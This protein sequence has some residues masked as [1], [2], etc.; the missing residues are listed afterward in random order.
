MQLLLLVPFQGT[1]A[2]ILFLLSIF[3]IALSCLNSLTY[4]LRYLGA[5]L[6]QVQ[7]RAFIKSYYQSIEFV[8]VSVISDH[9]R[10]IAQVGRLLMECRNLPNRGNQNFELND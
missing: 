2:L 3:P 6:C 1:R 7:E 4:D 8:C 5:R 9:M 10:I